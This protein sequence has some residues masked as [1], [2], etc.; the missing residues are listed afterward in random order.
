MIVSDQ[1]LSKELI[2]KLQLN[3]LYLLKE[4]NDFCS[5]HMIPFTLDF[6]SIIGAI[7]HRGFIPWDD[8][9]DI[10]MLRWDYDVFLE[11]TKQWNN[12]QIFVQNYDTDPQY[13][14]SFT[15]L[16][17][18]NS[19]AL[20]EEWSHLDVHHGIFID[21]FPYDVMPSSMGSIRLHEEEISILQEAK[22]KRVK[23]LGDNDKVL[24]ERAKIHCPLALNS[25]QELNR[26]Q[27]K[28]MSKYN[29]THRDSDFVTH[30]TRGFKT[31]REYRRRIHDHLRPSYYAFEKILLPIP[32][33]YQFILHNTYGDYLSFP[34]SSQR[35]P[36][37]GLIELEFNEKI[38][39]KI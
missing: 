13:V 30:M 4:F 21:I 20:Q 8:D 23:L 7:R 29:E 37:H 11:M 15:R 6:G 31:Y 17:L 16:R 18:N 26:M 32:N 22:L 12:E 10:A 19:K 28:V 38:N 35:K 34:P 36:H 24:W 2:R 9:I 33:N 3:E 39:M 14:H 27:T 25:M 5:K 1:T